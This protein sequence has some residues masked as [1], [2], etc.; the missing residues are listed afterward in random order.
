MF[1]FYHYF[2]VNLVYIFYIFCCRSDKAKIT[3]GGLSGTWMIS[4]LSIV[5]YRVKHGRFPCMRVRMHLGGFGNPLNRDVTTAESIAMNSILRMCDD[6]VSR[7]DDDIHLNVNADQ[8]VSLSTMNAAAQIVQEGVG[9][10]DNTD[11]GIIDLGEG[12]RQFELYT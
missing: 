4:M 9:R 12:G 1:M 2:L 8:N 3:V 6:D 10:G 11:A 5:L 7:D